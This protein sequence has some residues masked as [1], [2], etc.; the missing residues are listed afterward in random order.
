MRIN[1]K[2]CLTVLFSIICFMFFPQ[3][4]FAQNAE[5][6]KLEIYSKLKCCSCKESFDKCACSEAKEMKAYIDALLENGMGKEDIFFRVAKKYSIN[7]VIDP[8]IR[9]MVEQRLIRE[10]GEKRPQIVLEAASFNFG[11]VSKKQGK[12][13]KIFKVYSKGNA[14]LV[15]T[16]L[17][18][19][20]SCVTASLRV[21][22]N[23]SPYFG[24]SGAQAG[25]NEIIRP[26]DFGKLE[27][28]LDL[29]HSSMG[30]GKQIRDV[31][32]ES[33]DP[34]YPQKSFRVEVE[35]KE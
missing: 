31:F 12:L 18:V 5:G 17:R 35:V 21:G 13:S 6:V 10:A 33:N 7:T 9:Q 28:V 16:N 1:Y 27:V 24:T 14:D 20:C 2:I 15:I 22:K 3:L 11:S 19:S 29:K 30:M 8:Q 25:W 32:I 34:V 4:T 26:G 23:K